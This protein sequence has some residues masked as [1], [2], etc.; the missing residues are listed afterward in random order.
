[1]QTPCRALSLACE[2]EGKSMAKSTPMT[3]TTA[4]N[5]IIVKVFDFWLLAWITNEISSGKNR[6][7]L[8]KVI[9]S[10]LASSPEMRTLNVI[11]MTQK[12]TL[13]VL[14]AGMGS[15]FGGL[16]QLAPVGPNGELIIDY[17]IFDAARAG[18]G[19]VVFVIR[20]ELEQE[21]RAVIGARF[22]GHINVAYA[23]QDLSD[24]PSGFEV[25]AGRTKPW[26]TGHALRAAR[27]NVDG[28]CC[29]VNAD[30]FYGARAYEL[31]GKHLATSAPS[32]A[33]VGYSVGHTLSDAGSVSR[34][35]CR[36]EDGVLQAIEE[37]HGIQRSGAEVRNEAGELL[38]DAQIVSMN[39]WGF[40]SSVF[41]ELEAGFISFLN[42]GGEGEYY[43]PTIVENGMAAG[44]TVHLLGV[45]DTWT[46]VTY[47]S[48]QPAVAR[49]LLDLH[50]S[51]DYPPS[52]LPE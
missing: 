17:T 6:I 44:R 9:P 4:I 39:F 18:F 37:V 15:R 49:L 36:C 38:G 40:P 19:H 2:S 51:G 16:K 23:F 24:L 20:R 29:V 7:Q 21:F 52:L 31:M 34:G 43:L 33:L 25:P 13:I 47:A 10:A 50:A 26:G 42:A 30:D 14:A 27:H 8:Y 41:T 32:Y 48:D 3:M 46:G 22:D 45:C 28:P 11:K 12:P 5:S 1:M 35:V